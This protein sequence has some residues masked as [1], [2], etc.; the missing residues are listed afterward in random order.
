MNRTIM[1]PFRTKIV[2]PIG[3][4]MEAESIE[5]LRAEHDDHFLLRSRETHINLMT[6]GPS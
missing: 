2:E 4:S 1:V 3:I 5:Q 6:P